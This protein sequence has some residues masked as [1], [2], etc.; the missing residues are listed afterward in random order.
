MR[1]FHAFIPMIV[2]ISNYAKFF[3]DKHTYSKA[4][5]PAIENVHLS[6]A[7]KIGKVQIL[8]V[9]NTNLKL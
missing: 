7:E 4:R 2:C 3:H 1:P 5:M 8:L 9:Q 6:W